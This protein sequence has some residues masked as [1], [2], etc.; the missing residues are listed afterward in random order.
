MSITEDQLDER[1]KHRTYTSGVIKESQSEYSK[2][3]L[4]L[5]AAVLALSVAFLKSVVSI[6]SAIYFGLLYM[7][8]S[9]LLTAVL[10]TLIAIKV[11]IKAHQLYLVDLDHEIADM[12]Q[13]VKGETWRDAWM[14]RFPWIASL[15]FSLGV[16]GLVVFSIINIQRERRMTD[17]NQK[18]ILREVQL[19]NSDWHKIQDHV[20]VQRLP[21]ITQ[22]APAE[23][24]LTTPA[25][26][27][28][29]GS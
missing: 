20:E 11:S 3:L 8:W 24:P 2:Q 29:R 19:P 12:H 21:P 5:S 28:T 23:K 10:I 7:S 18:V 16:L 4:S 27:S 14:P 22:P 9:L 26:H 6:K 1:R 25:P 15:S 13:L 17:E